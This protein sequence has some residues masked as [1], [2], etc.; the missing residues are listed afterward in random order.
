MQNQEFSKIARQA[1]DA[2]QTHPIQI[3]ILLKKTPP[4]LFLMTSSHVRILTA[5]H[6]DSKEYKAT[7]DRRVS[8]SF[9]TSKWTIIMMDW[10]ASQEQWS[11]SVVDAS[12]N[13]QHWWRHTSFPLLAVCNGWVHVYHGL[14]C[15][16]MMTMWMGYLGYNTRRW[17]RRINGK[18][19]AI[20]FFRTV[21]AMNALLAWKAHSLF[22]GNS[23][24]LWYHICR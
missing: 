13:L 4:R 3:K 8:I 6:I 15:N 23:I 9:W 18:A 10:I 24:S 14:W 19:R 16:M 2:S 12:V 22:D 17:T 1:F 21:S 5:V 11:Q 7:I 20:I